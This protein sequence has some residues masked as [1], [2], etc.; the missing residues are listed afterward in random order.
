H[1]LLTHAHLDHIRGIPFLADNLILKNKK[2]SVQ[3]HAISAVLRD[4]K[5]NLL[6]DRIWPDFTSIPS[7][8]RPIL[9]L[10]TIRV[11]KA[12]TL[13]GYRI[14]TYHVNHSV[15][16]TGYVVENKR[17]KRIL[18]TGDTGPTD[19]IW[20]E[21]RKRVHLAIIEVS[22]PNRMRQMAIKTGHLTAS[23]LKAEFKKMETIPDKILITHPKPQYQRKIKEEL[24]NLKMKNVRLLRDGESFVV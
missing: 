11:G 2:H 18:Y 4:L 21:C 3:I 5:K 12:F 16:A 17:G 20:K 7:Q 10:K 24:R 23:L 19:R 22:M 14:T 1:I 13:N 9:R 6:N 15:P 8:E